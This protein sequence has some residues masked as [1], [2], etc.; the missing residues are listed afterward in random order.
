ML[1]H[2]G[3]VC[4]IRMAA[5]LS[6]APV[7]RRGWTHP[8]DPRRPPQ[9]GPAG[10]RHDT[11]RP[12]GPRRREVAARATAAHPGGAPRPD[13]AA[14]TASRPVLG[15]GLTDG[16][17]QRA[18][19]WGPAWRRSRTTTW[20]GSALR[21]RQAS[22][23]VRRRGR[24][25]SAAGRGTADRWGL[26]YPAL[27]LWAWRGCALLDAVSPGRSWAADGSAG[28]DA[29]AAR[30]LSALLDAADKPPGAAAVLAGQRDPEGAAIA[31]DLALHGWP[32]G[33]AGL[34]DTG[35][36]RDVWE[37]VAPV[38]ALAL[39]VM[40]QASCRHASSDAAFGAVWHFRLKS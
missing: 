36:G 3:T 7:A 26:A 9:A 2:A 23:A 11:V 28:L 27:L 4:P 34:L 38:F 13:R 32:R 19:E 25:S 24:R 39:A 5:G 35:D 31:A 18:P 15:T 20:P 6:R 1:V 12:A 37:V 30:L 14:A 8:T 21:C 10:R 16:K 33:V 40:R 22:T 29:R 17:A